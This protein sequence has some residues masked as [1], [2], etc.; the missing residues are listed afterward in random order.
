MLCFTRLYV[1]IITILFNCIS[2]FIVANTPWCLKTTE[3]DQQTCNFYFVHF[4]KTV[5]IQWWE[6]GL[7]RMFN[8]IMLHSIVN[9]KNMS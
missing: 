4:L 2:L 6:K 5:I 9:C 7:R 8:Y 1:I 3:S